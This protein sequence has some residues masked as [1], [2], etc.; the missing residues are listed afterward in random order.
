VASTKS[1]RLW[2]IGLLIVSVVLAGLTVYLGA[3]KH[4]NTLAAAILQAVTIVF[5]TG[6]AFVFARASVQSAAQEMIRGQARSPFRRVRSIYRELGSVLEA[7]DQQSAR[8]LSLR[9]GDNPSTLDYEY[10]DLAMQMLRHLITVQANTADDAL[11]DWR[12]LVPDEVQ[13]IE[14]EVEEARRLR[15][16]GNAA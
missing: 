12:D 9:Q 15:G 3:L 10:V 14:E 8:F 11:A 5:S 6:G 16:D 7:L 4:P 1:Q 13:Q 2:G